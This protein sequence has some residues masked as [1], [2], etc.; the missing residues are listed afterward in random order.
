MVALVG[1]GQGRETMTFF[2]VQEVSGAQRE[3]ARRS[4]GGRSSSNTA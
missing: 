1:M 3:I 2:L 4:I